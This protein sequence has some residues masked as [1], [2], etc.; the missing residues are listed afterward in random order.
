M[1]RDNGPRPDPTAWVDNRQRVEAR[2]AIGDGVAA[3]G[4]VISYCDAPTVT[5]ETDD[6]RRVSWRVDLTVAVSDLSA[7]PIGTVRGMGDT[8]QPWAKRNHN[9]WVC[10]THDETTDDREMAGCPVTGAVP[11]TPAAEA[12]TPLSVELQLPPV[13]VDNEAIVQGQYHGKR[14]REPRPS[15][16]V[17]NEPHGVP[18]H[19]VVQM[20]E[21]LRSGNKRGAV[22]LL[23]AA[24]AIGEDEAGSYVEG[25]SEY[26]SYLSEHGGETRYFR[27]R[28]GTTFRTAADGR[29]EVLLGATWALAEARLDELLARPYVREIN[30]TE[31]VS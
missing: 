30:G 22:G 29:M 6:G 20:V 28:H 1:T 4:A 18:S 5:I 9:E 2:Y 13:H 25:M 3:V 27:D 17:V 24:M 10:I 12:Q 21:L 31:V 14:D 8:L 7:D 15:V 23:A 26:Q 19:I 16:R 11:G